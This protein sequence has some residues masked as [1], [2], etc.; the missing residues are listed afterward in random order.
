MPIRRRR[1]SAENA[2]PTDTGH[3]S[4]AVALVDDLAIPEQATPSQKEMSAFRRLANFEITAKKIKLKAL[5]QFSRQLSVFLTAGVPVIDALRVIREDVPDKFFAKI[6]DEMVEALKGGTTFAGAAAEHADAFPP[7]YLGVLEA[8]EYTGNLDTVLLQLSDYIE[9]DL[10]ARRKVVSALIYPAVIAVLCVVVVIILVTY[11]LPK[12]ETFF[13][14]LNAKLPLPT[15]ILL[16]TSHW[17]T[18]HWYVFAAIG[19]GLIAFG[20]WLTQ[21]TGGRE[22][23][24]RAVLRIPVLGDVVRH[25]VLERFCRTLSA[26]MTAGVP[27]VSALVVAGDACSNVIYRKGIAS[28]RGEMLRG[29]GLAGPLADTGLFPASAR[30]IFRVGEATGSLDGQLHIAAEY[31]ERELD[32]KIKRFTS[33]FEPLVIVIMGAAVAF[34]AVAMVSAMYGI[35]R[36]VKVH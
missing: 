5:S 32:Y 21:T 18:H 29:S 28:A 17:I 11:V 31:F 12:F 30:Q 23:R 7:Y 8:A 19:T 26:M 6:L 25:A 24:D 13:K 4:G 27:L 33:L 16:D 14:D 36:Q 20:F 35:F 34:V 9:R 15:R 22:A 2:M 10:E 3:A 1:A